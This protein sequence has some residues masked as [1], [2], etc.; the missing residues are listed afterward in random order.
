LGFY[1]AESRKPIMLFCNHPLL[2]SL[3]SHRTTDTCPVS[4]NVCRYHTDEFGIKRSTGDANLKATQTYPVGFG[5][6]VAA[7]F[8]E[9][10]P[11]LLGIAPRLSPVPIDLVGLFSDTDDWPDANLS[12]VFARL[13]DLNANRGS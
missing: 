10:R 4:D 7:V 3:E 12:G 5:I 11:T 1:G 6:G 9:C 2:Q 13:W 8:C